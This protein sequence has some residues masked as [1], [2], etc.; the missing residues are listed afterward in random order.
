[1]GNRVEKQ[2]RSKEQQNRSKEQQDVQT[3][4]IEICENY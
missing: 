1:M 3:K 2:N 4:F